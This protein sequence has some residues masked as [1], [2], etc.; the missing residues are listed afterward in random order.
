MQTFEIVIKEIPFK[1]KNISQ[2]VRSI[3]EGPQDR[4]FI[5]CHKQAVMEL[6][7]KNFKAKGGDL[8]ISYRPF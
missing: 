3:K 6:D 5:Q 1:L 7:P 4:L 2:Y 8:Y